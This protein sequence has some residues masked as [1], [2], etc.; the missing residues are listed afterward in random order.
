M[1]KHSYKSAEI[2]SFN[3]PPNTLQ[4]QTVTVL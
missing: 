1:G 2:T 4:M 3:T